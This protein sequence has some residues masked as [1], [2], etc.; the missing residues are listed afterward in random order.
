MN[1]I[2]NRIKELRMALNGGNGMKQS[3][4]A[5]KLGLKHGIVSLWEQGK[6]INE[7]TLRAICHAFNVSENWLKNGSGEMFFVPSVIDEVI[8]DKFHQ[9]T[10]KVQKMVLDYMDILLENDNILHSP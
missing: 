4:F 1:A 10:P 5:D 9:L 7:R 8:L 3:E 2:G 6:N